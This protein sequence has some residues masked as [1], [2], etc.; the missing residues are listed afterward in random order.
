MG[1][2]LLIRERMMLAM[3]GDPFT[4]VD[5]GGDP[6]GGPEHHFDGRVQ[7]Q[8]SMGRG[9]VQK[10]RRREDGDLDQCNSHQERDYERR[11]HSRPSDCVDEGGGAPSY[12]PLWATQNDCSTKQRLDP[13]LAVGPL[14]LRHELDERI[15]SGL[16]KRVVDGRPQPTDRAVALE[17][18]ESCVPSV[19]REPSLE[20]R[21]RQPEGDV[22][23]RSAVD[24][25]RASI[26]PRP[27]DRRVEYLGLA[28]VALG[29][30][31]SPPFA[32]SHFMTSPT[33]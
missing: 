8:R 4:R 29:M 31:G 16:R 20:L 26:E 24:P 15:D 21:T 19:L 30:A 3:H 33:R 17:T 11:Q 6:L 7:D 23:Q 13:L 12:Q 22:H 32:S 2:S 14:E 5:A 25:S 1:I 27:V 18:G 28:L 10:D 9:A